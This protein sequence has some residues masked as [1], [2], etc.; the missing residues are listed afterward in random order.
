VRG[1]FITLIFVLLLIMVT[2]VSLPSLL[3]IDGV[4]TSL[5]SAMATQLKRRVVIDAINGS[6]WQGFQVKGLRIYDQS[7][8]GISP[9]A[10]L[11]QLDLVIHYRDLLTGKL[12]I[13]VQLHGMNI[14]LIRSADGRLNIDDLMAGSTAAEETRPPDSAPLSLPMDIQIKV[15]IDDVNFYVLDELN[16]QDIA[17]TDVSLV[18]NAPD[19][20]GQPIQLAYGMTPSINGQSF[21]RVT[22]Q[23]EISQLFSHRTL[24]V[25]QIIARLDVRLPGVDWQLKAAMPQAQVDS[26]LLI[27][28]AQLLPPIATMIEPLQAVKATANIA[29]ETKLQN[30]LSEDIQFFSHLSVNELSAQHDQWFDQAI[31]GPALSLK[32]DGS[33][34]ITKQQL[35]VDQGMLTIGHRSTAQWQMQVNDF[36]TD[37]KQL[38]GRVDLSFDLSEIYDTV[39]PVLSSALFSPHNDFLLALNDANLTVKKLNVNLSDNLADGEISAQ[40]LSVVIAAGHFSMAKD[41]IGVDGFAFNI[42][43]LQIKLQDELPH[44]L[45]LLSSDISLAGLEYQGQE[46]LSLSQLKLHMSSDPVVLANQGIGPLMFNTSLSIDKLLLS[47]E[48]PLELHQLRMPVQ[49]SVKQLQENNQALLGWDMHVLLTPKITAKAIHLPPDLSLTQVAGAFDVEYASQPTSVVKLPNFSLA[50]DTLRVQDKH[51]QALSVAASVGRLDLL[52]LDPFDFNLYDQQLEV[53]VADAVYLFAESAMQGSGYQSLEHSGQLSVDLQQILPWIPAVETIQIDKLSGNLATHWH[54][55]GQRPSALQISQIENISKAPDGLLEATNFVKQLQLQMTLQDGLADIKLMPNDAIV[56]GKF[57]A[58]KLFSVMARNGLSEMDVQADWRFQDIS[59]SYTKDYLPA[60]FDTSLTLALS[61]KN[62]NE[63]TLN[64]Q[65]NLQPL[66]V[67]QNLNLSLSGLA[68]VLNEGLQQPLLS[69]LRWLQGQLDVSVLVAQDNNFST[70]QFS[71]TGLTHLWTQLQ[72]HASQEVVADIWWKTEDFSVAM[73]AQFEIAQ[74]ATDIHLHKSYQLQFGRAVNPFAEQPS[75]LSQSVLNF[76]PSMTNSTSLNQAVVSNLKPPNVKMRDL[77]LYGAPP[78]PMNVKYPQLSLLLENNLPSLENIELGLLGGTLLGDVKILKKAV[79][80][81]VAAKFSFSGVDIQNLLPATAQQAD[82]DAE[83]SGLIEAHLPLEDDTI[84]WLN[85]IELNIKITHIG[86]RAME[87]L[88]FALDPY[89]TNEA[90]IEQRKL[91]K[92]GK[93]KWVSIVIKNGLLNLYGEL[94]LLS[95]SIDL[96]PLERLDLTSLPMDWSE[97]IQPFG[98]LRDYMDK[99]S[100]VT[101]LL[102]DH[103]S[104]TFQ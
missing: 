63:L 52:N 95:I 18:F 31:I 34:N 89:E 87:R 97:I 46:K 37:N 48:T 22:L 19:I 83:V 79:H 90:I 85:N 62:L 75:L 2:V 60:D 4:R 35:A 69:G 55:Q 96:P 98:D 100:A 54:L 66:A 47:G 58:P 23:A 5:Q 104:I 20:A 99:L 33:L 30:V 44:Y 14:Q 67:T 40:A 101:V 82:I 74:L 29:L 9:F 57:Q 72:L 61:Q 51:L 77:Y 45:H 76:S 21:E 38:H 27:D 16:Q 81:F 24:S 84:Y 73:P 71:L 56:I 7:A 88:L 92:S 78:L 59:T 64:Q 12:N 1:F 102:D 13:S 8:V 42:A 10:E 25:E 103:E 36:S 94:D 3:S 26:R 41:N 17:L 43:D 91:L 32:N 15:V 86:A 39:K 49:L 50:V 68:N 80:Y 70:D 65:L 28:V 11:H 53:K 6:W 93:P